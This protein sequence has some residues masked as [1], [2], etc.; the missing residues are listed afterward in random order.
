MNSS[1]Y[2]KSSLKD[3]FVRVFC[4]VG[5]PFVLYFW[6]LDLQYNFYI[7]DYK[8]TQQQEKFIVTQHPLSTKFEADISD[9]SPLSYN[10]YLLSHISHFWILAFS[11]LACGLFLPLNNR[12][13]K[14]KA[15]FVLNQLSQELTHVNSQRSSLEQR[16]L[17][18]GNLIQRSRQLGGALHK[19]AKKVELFEEPGSFL[20]YGEK[21][22]LIKATAALAED[23]STGLWKS[24]QKETISVEELLEHL[25]IYF[26]DKIQKLNL[27]YTFT[28][29]QG[30]EFEGDPLFT[31]I[32]LLNIIG[33]P[34]YS[35]PKEG[36]ISIAVTEEKGFVHIEVKG[37]QYSLSTEGKKYLKFPPDLLIEDT[38]LQESC[39]QH[40]I[41][42]QSET[43]GEE[44]CTLVSFPL[45]PDDGR[46]SNVIPFSRTLH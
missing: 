40:G 1:T 12:I 19:S 37:K 14:K 16:T 4:F 32:I 8:A 23:L 6:H 13:L 11:V 20:S 34:L 46:E 28:C 41:G 43:Q 17:L 22:T 39:L 31:K 36:E 24:P 10:A 7:E 42:Y 29:P 30:L 27:K 5:L 44:F 38:K 45:I 26:T 18:Q 3:I 9:E 2:L 35:M 25:K 21:Q 33:I 15:H